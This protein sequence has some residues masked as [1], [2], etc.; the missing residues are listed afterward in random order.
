A[1]VGH[2]PGLVPDQTL[3]HITRKGNARSS[4]IY[5]VHAGGV[6]KLPHRPPPGVIRRPRFCQFWRIQGH[7]YV[8]PR[9]VF[10]D[11]GM[12]PIDLP[13]DRPDMSRVHIVDPTNVHPGV[14]EQ[15][16]ETWGQTRK[17]VPHTL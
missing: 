10:I 15:A 9:A 8:W 11:P 5:I 6:D 4:A 13:A 1:I 17:G 2:G 7:A 12:R 3:P 16:N 14:P